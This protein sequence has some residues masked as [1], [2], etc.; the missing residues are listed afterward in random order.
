MD[1]DDGAEDQAELESFKTLTREE[2]EVLRAKYPPLSPW[3]VVAVQAVVGGVIAV[4]WW[5]FTGLGA[6]AWSALCGAAAVVLPNALMAWGMTGLFR[7]VPGAAVLGFMFWELIKIMLTV[8]AL[9]AAAIWMPDLSW[10]AMLVALIG[11]LKVNWLALL[12]Q[13]RKSRNGN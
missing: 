1:W 10:P 6:N 12:W 2:A 3:R 4:L 13:G 9:V 5:L 7:G 11:C 8:A